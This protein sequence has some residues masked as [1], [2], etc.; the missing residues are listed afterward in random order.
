M[1]KPHISLGKLQCQYQNVAQIVVEAWDVA[2]RVLR[3]FWL[4]TIGKIH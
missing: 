3:N 2:F 1:N 4:T